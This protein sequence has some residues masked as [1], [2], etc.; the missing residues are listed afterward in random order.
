MLKKAIKMICFMLL[1][2]FLLA[3]SAYSVVSET[4]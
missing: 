3:G 4:R 2:L 1:F